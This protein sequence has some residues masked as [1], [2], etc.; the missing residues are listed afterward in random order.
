M[1]NGTGLQ[2][3]GLKIGDY[4]AVPDRTLYNNIGPQC[5]T[6]RKPYRQCECP[7]H[8]DVPG[9]PQLRP[10]AQRQAEAME[11]IAVQLGKIVKHL[12]AQ[13]LERSERAKSSGDLTIIPEGIPPI[14]IIG[15]PDMPIAP[16]ILD[17]ATLA[18]NEARKAETLAKLGGGKK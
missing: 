16:P 2:D 10:A 13:A 5:A 1:S 18:K 8:V 3:V 6:C 9:E 12:D 17:E 14:S 15:S 7:P 4:Q 11:I